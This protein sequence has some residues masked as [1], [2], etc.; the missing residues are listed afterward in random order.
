MCDAELAPPM[1]YAKER[2]MVGAKSRNCGWVGCEW[3]TGQLAAVTPALVL[4]HGPTGLAP[5]LFS[6]SDLAHSP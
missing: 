1:L 5:N 2:E 6:F 3:R 4:L